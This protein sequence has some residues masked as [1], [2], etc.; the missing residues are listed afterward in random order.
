MLAHVCHEH[1]NHLVPMCPRVASQVLQRVD[2][3]HADIDALV[4][5]MLDG[6]REPV[7]VLSAARQLE[8]TGS[9]VRA[10]HGNRTS[11]QGDEAGP[12]SSPLGALVGRS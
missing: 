12:Y 7:S 11:S 10:D 6:T 4:P 2:S 3:A 8:R 9:E 1:F 5:K